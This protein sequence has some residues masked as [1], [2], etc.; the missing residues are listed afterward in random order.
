MGDNACNDEIPGVSDDIPRGMCLDDAY[1]AARGASVKVGMIGLGKLGLPVALAMESKGMVVRGHDPHKPDGPVCLYPLPD[2]D[3]IEPL[4]KASAICNCALSDVV[5]WADVIFVAVQTPHAKELD[6]ARLLPEHRADFGYDHLRTAIGG[7]VGAYKANGRKRLLSLA[8]ISTVLPG[9]MRREIIPHLPPGLELV[10]NPYFVAMGTVIE[11]FLRPEFVLLGADKGQGGEVDA[12]YEKLYGPAGPHRAWMSIESAELTKVA[13]NLFISQKIDFANTLQEVADR[14][15]NCDVDEVTDAI[16]N[17]KRRLISGKYLRAG[18]EDGGACHPRDAVAMSWLTNQLGVSNPFEQLMN[19]RQ[20]RTRR[21]VAEV[22]EHAEEKK[23]PIFIV[24][25]SFKAGSRLVDGSWGMLIADLFRSRG[26]PFG[27]VDAVVD[28]VRLDGDWDIPKV[29][30]IATAHDEHFRI[31]A[32]PG[33][34]VFDPFGRFPSRI[35]VEVV[36][37]GRHGRNPIR[38][39]LRDLAE[40][41]LGTAADERDNLRALLHDLKAK[42]I[43]I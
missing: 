36:R 16:C 7:V 13:Y 1:I 29:F 15:P 43:A 30:L 11:D 33:S 37:I 38:D 42:G 25:K 28:D 6:G 17:A 8:V 3:G 24:G 22:W 27:H 39:L 18:G 9:T 34:V 35:G 26:I 21:L 31:K 41:P 19:N 40:R 12:F 4:M 20:E 2:E 5:G 10:Y 32:P 23:L 14:I